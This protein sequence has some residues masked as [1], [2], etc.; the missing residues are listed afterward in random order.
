MYSSLFTVIDSD[1]YVSLIAQL[2]EIT[3]INSA[4]ESTITC[5]E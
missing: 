1:K 3:V 2:I 4:G 5:L